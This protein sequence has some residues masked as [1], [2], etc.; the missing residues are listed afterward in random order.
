MKGF[1]LIRRVRS[2]ELAVIDHIAI[3]PRH[4]S[5]M[6]SSSRWP[7]TAALGGTEAPRLSLALDQTSRPGAAPPGTAR[8]GGTLPASTGGVG[9]GDAAAA[10]CGAVSGAAGASLAG[11]R[12]PGSG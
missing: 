1:W 12:G 5:S 2:V 4:T 3:T 10:G 7:T 8:G 11:T 9:R 6:R